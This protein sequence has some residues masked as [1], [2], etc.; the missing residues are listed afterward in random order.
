MLTRGKKNIAHTSKEMGTRIVRSLATETLNWD[1]TLKGRRRLN[2][3]QESGSRNSHSP[4]I[5]WDSRSKHKSTDCLKKMT[6]LSFS[7]TVLGMSTRARKL[8]ESAL[9]NKKTT[10]NS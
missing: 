4:E 2:I 1:L 8:R 3:N 6:M 7:H 9:F 10:K 5:W